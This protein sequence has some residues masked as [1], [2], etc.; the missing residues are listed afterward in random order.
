MDVC[1]E[2]PR[3][4]L[5]RFTPEDVNNLWEV[6]SDPEVMRHLNGGRPTPYDVICDTDIPRFLAYHRDHEG[7]G[8]W[9]AEEKGTGEFIGR[10]FLKLGRSDPEAL[11]LGY[12]LKR[13]AWGRGYATEGVGALVRTAFVDL[14]APMVT[15][16]TTLENRASWRVMEK[17]GMSCVRAFVLE[18]PG[19]WHHGREAVEYALTRQEWEAGS[20][21]GLLEIQRS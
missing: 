7:L 17:A 9:A 19:R 11:E 5:R 18:G 15:A 16:F 12:R 6:E 1:L 4:A 13:S 8:Y 3:L 20:G 2:T 14:A 21:R 10:F